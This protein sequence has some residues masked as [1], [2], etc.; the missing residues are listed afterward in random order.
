MATV[1]SGTITET[2]NVQ[3]K[4]DGG[5]LSPTTQQIQG[6]QVNDAWTIAN[7]TGT[8]QANA[9]FVDRR[10]LG[11]GANETL[12]LQALL[13]EHGNTLVFT[14]IKYIKIKP[15]AANGATLEIGGA[16]SNAWTALFGASTHTNK[17]RAGGK[18]EH[19]ELTAGYAVSGSSKN[20]KITNNDGAAS[21]IYDIII[22]GVA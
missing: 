11:N 3:Y 21:A 15:A 8:L 14:A 7:G 19:Q 9:T 6:G 2:L 17:E 1:L 10:T 13:D 12:D 5:G 20:L 18:W 4:D 16:A 22:I